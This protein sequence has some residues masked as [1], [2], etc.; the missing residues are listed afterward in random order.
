MMLKMEPSDTLALAHGRK[1]AAQEEEQGAAE[2][3]GPAPMKPRELIQVS[4]KIDCMDF[5]C[6]GAVMRAG[7]CTLQALHTPP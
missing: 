4:Y 6:P 1:N 2:R 5:R 7:L 3:H